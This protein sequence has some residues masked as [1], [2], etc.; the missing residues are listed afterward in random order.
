[1]TVVVCRKVGSRMHVVEAVLMLPTLVYSSG[2]L[3]LFFW[4]FGLS[5]LALHHA[6]PPVTH[7]PV[8]AQLEP[9]SIT[10]I[11]PVLPET[12]DQLP[13]LLKPFLNPPK[14]NR[15]K[16]S[17]LIVL[18]PESSLVLVRRE[19]QAAFVFL[20][21]AL[22]MDLEISLFPWSLRFPIDDS[23]ELSLDTDVALL[24]AVSHLG[25][26]EN[27]MILLM[28]P[29]GLSSLSSSSVLALLSPIL[30]GADTLPLGPYGAKA[31]SYP[32]IS[33]TSEWGFSLD[34]QPAKYLY[35][36]FIISSSLVMSFCEHLL[37]LEN[38]EQTENLN[39]VNT[40][41]WPLLG[42]LVSSSRND[43]IGGLKI[44]PPTFTDFQDPYSSFSESS[45]GVSNSS[46]SLSKTRAPLDFLFIFSSLVDLHHASSLICLL[47]ANSTRPNILIILHNLSHIPTE[48]E[49]VIWESLV[50]E[51]DQN[52][53]IPYENL[54]SSSYPAFSTWF[55]HRLSLSRLSIHILVTVKEST[56]F[57]PFIISQIPNIFN[58][59]T[60]ISIPRADL[61][62][63]DWIASLSI[64]ELKSGFLPFSPTQSST[65]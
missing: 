32:P 59:T 1:M 21:P 2:F 63:T 28:D 4:L 20:R 8:L 16:I 25:L 51:N 9:R 52:C 49:D 11:L 30:L 10:A 41:I 55:L 23:D 38:E 18:S 31:E 54:A 53:S 42:L 44:Q 35:P 6:Q 39:S 12:V 14:H 19:L 60:H 45:N 50:V 29:T 56:P 3:L 27:T 46:T 61:A 5:D 17:E 40:N 47:L 7:S 43:S 33:S 24:R 36:P 15:S 64:A 62:H 65:S 13:D 58:A 48:P 37:L 26:E 22:D 57:L 34:L